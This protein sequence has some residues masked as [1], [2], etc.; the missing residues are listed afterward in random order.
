MTV[1]KYGRSHKPAGLPQ[2]V[3]GTY[4]TVAGVGGDD[5]LLDGFTSYLAE[6]NG[7]R[8]DHGIIELENGTLQYCLD[9]GTV[10][11]DPTGF[12]QTYFVDAQPGDFNASKVGDSGTILF[13]SR[14]NISQQAWREAVGWLREQGAQTSI[15]NLDQMSVEQARELAQ[16]Q[17]ALLNEHMNRFFDDF[18]RNHRFVVQEKVQFNRLRQELTDNDPDVA[19]LHLDGEQTLRDQISTA[20]RKLNAMQVLPTRETLATL[21][22]Q[23]MIQANPELAEHI[24]EP[25]KYDLSQAQAVLDGLKHGVDVEQYNDPDMYTGEQ[26]RQVY[27]GLRFKV[28]VSLYNDPTRYTAKQMYWVR[29]G[30]IDGVDVRRY[31]HP[32]KYN[33]QAMERAYERAMAKKQRWIANPMIHY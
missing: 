10:F 20:V 3:A 19:T 18:E 8:G 23:E 5:D 33:A 22:I 1:D 25:K 2:H 4:D 30:L 6:T 12:V 9:K 32:E 29:Q 21:D 11:S 27:S 26:M 17:R 28:D 13:M 7:I 24:R 31:N 14:E 16:N 15:N